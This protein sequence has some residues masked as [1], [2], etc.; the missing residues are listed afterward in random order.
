MSVVGADSLPLLSR[1]IKNGGRV[2]CVVN[3][4]LGAADVAGFVARQDMLPFADHILVVHDTAWTHN[5]SSTKLR[6]LLLAGDVGAAAE[7]LPAGS[8]AYL[9]AHLDL[10]RRPP[11]PG[12]APLPFVQLTDVPPT[13]HLTLAMFKDDGA[14]I[15]HGVQSTV[16]GMQWPQFGGAAVA[17]KC[18]TDKQARKQLQTEW[19]VW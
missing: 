3:R 17:I 6:A 19:R 2:V 1:S 14:V 11:S 4:E 12:L 9:Q 16:R 5:Y 18:F 7:M 15:G 8:L 10:Y 13:Q